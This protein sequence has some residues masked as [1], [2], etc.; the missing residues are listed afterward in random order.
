MSTSIVVK[1]NDLKPDKKDSAK[2]VK[3]LTPG[4]E[5]FLT[6]LAKTFVKSVL[7]QTRTQ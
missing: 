3:I 1:I 4:E 5:A 6:L 2:V 7:S